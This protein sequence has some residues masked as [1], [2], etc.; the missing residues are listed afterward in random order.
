MISVTNIRKTFDSLTAVDDV[1]FEVEKGEIFGLL[2]PNGAGKTTTINMMV[3]ALKPDSGSISI[4][5]DGDPMRTEI[6]MKIGAAPQALA[7]YEDMT[8]EENVIFFGKLYG[9]RGRKLKERVDWT[10]E[11]VGLTER[12]RDRASTYSG[13]MKRRLNLACSLVHDPQVLLFDEPTVG[14]DPQSRNLIFD[15]IEVLRGE[16]R[17]IV[18]TTHYMEEAQRLCDRVAIIDHGKILDLDTVDNL[19]DRHGGDAVVTALVDSPGDISVSLPGQLEGDQLR[20]TS[21]RPLEEVAM[22]NSSG[23]RF[24]SLKVD[25]ADLESVFLNLTGRRLRD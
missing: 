23:V 16:G 14:V 7:I 18:Y 10:L 20:F 11:L 13:G 15:N 17:T 5:G 1:S 24:R 19:I 3:G 22:L 6:R 4:D 2:G 12:C 21:S 8:A 25:R 9:I